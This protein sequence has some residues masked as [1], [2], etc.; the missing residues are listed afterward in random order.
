MSAGSGEG[1]KPGQSAPTSRLA[2]LLTVAKRPRASCG[3]ELSFKER[4]ETFP[5]KDES[6]CEGCGKT[7]GEDYDWFAGHSTT[8]ILC[9]SCADAIVE[10]EGEVANGN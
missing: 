8:G 6:A 10:V 2:M 3:D 9:P 7:I 4:T 5:K 1:A